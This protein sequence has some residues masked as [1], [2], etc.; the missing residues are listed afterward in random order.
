MKNYKLIILSGIFFFSLLIVFV[1]NP[2]ITL[3]QNAALRVVLAGK[4][5]PITAERR[6]Q[7][8]FVPVVPI[9]RELGYLVEIDAANEIIRVVRVG[10]EAEFNKRTS[11]IRENG[12][13]VSG[14]PFASEVVFSANKENI[15]LPV[16]VIGGLLNVSVT[17]N[18]SQNIVAINSKTVTSA[19]ISQKTEKFEMSGLDYTYS[20]NF[21]NKSYY[22]TLNLTSSGRFGSSIY[23]SNLNFLG[24][25]SGRF[26]S[27]YGGNFALRRK[28]GDEFQFGDLTTSVGNEM[29]LM[30]TLVRGA[31]YSRPV[32][33]DKAKISFF[34]GRLYSGYTENLFRRRY[35]QSLQFDTTTF[36]SRFSYNPFGLKPNSVSLK[37]LSFSAGAM[38]Y[39]GLKNKGLLFDGTV[40]YNTQ[41]LNLFGEFAANSATYETPN[42]QLVSGFGSGIIVRGSYKPWNFLTLQ[43]GYEKFS[44]KFTNSSRLNTYS[45]RNSY[46]FGVGILPFKNL[47]LNASATFSSYNRPTIFGN[48]INREFKTTNYNGSLNYDPQVRFLPRF[49]VS[50][51]IIDNSTFGKYTFVNVN[52]SKD[53]KNVRLFGNYILT[54]S[55]NSKGHGFNLGANINA[56]KFGQFQVQQSLYFNKS[57]VFLEDLEC[58]INFQVC[59][60]DDPV[61]RMKLA[62]SG[63]NVDWSP[64][65]NLFKRLYLTV[66]AGYLKDSEKTGL[67]FRTTAGV[68]LPFKQ[69]LQVSYSK[70][71][72]Y[73]E[74][75]FSLSGSLAFWK[76]KDSF[77]NQLSDETFIDTGKIQGRVYADE[78]G[79]R[80]YDAGVD[81]PMSNVRV[82]LDNGREMKSDVNGNYYFES[83]SSGEHHL[84]LNLEDVRA[85]L[86]PANGLDYN[87]TTLPRSITDTSFRLVKSGS[88]SGRVWRDF[89][90]NHKF[91]EGEGLADIRLLS[92]SG[93]ST[94]SDSDGTFLLSDLP[95][96]EQSVFIDERYHPENLILE[97]TSLKVNVES[98]QE[99]SNCSFIYK[100]KPREIKEIT[101]GNT[102]TKP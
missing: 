16:E 58:R 9:A 6:G 2:L 71:T 72:Y 69:T 33:D 43:S 24:T 82:R 99:F 40:I 94:Y 51:N 31:S 42:K 41:K 81:A 60:N 61:Y 52:T 21:Y 102:N 89:N 11:D 55:N 54:D 101:F 49:S 15:L 10:V 35:N 4:E 95:P 12:V 62:S 67:Q 45:D 79:N 92:S 97:Q 30:N 46:N 7:R 65:E 88:V 59:Y 17:V 74:L 63:F 14:V 13:T 93:K 75:R 1:D 66:G 56:D 44:P 100:A 22:Q 64:K 19:I 70:N 39:N 36:G 84:S 37:N 28:S 27:F 5:L 29:T 47:S 98:G 78:N 87:V 91:D 73:S 32:F 38:F 18:D 96:G 80:Q 68:N 23:H 25:S 53:L 48:T 20:S 85:S 83:V 77:S 86:V 34:G 57:Q 76:K 90:E 8:I 26:F 3:S 50:A